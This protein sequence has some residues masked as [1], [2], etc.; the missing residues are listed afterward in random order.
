MPRD[1]VNV[2]L[3]ALPQPCAGR[4][5]FLCG[6]GGAGMNPLAHVLAARGALVSGSDACAQKSTEMLRAAGIACAIGHAAGQVRGADVFVYSS[7]IA[8]DNPEF[9]YARAHGIACLHRAHVLAQLVNQA[10][11]ITVAGTHGK[12]TTTALLALMLTTAG[13]DP[14]AVVGGVVPAFNAYHRLGQADWF[15]VETDE[16]DGSFQLFDSSLAVLL[17]IDA[18]H[19]DYYPDLAAIEAACARYVARIKP[20][21]TLV[22]NA[23][24]AHA[25][26]VAA[27]APAHVA[28]LACSCTGPASFRAQHVVLQPWS[29][30]FRV[31]E[32]GA[33]Y[34]VTVGVPGQH[35]VSNA[36]QALA[37]ARS[38]GVPVDAVQRACAAFHGVQR[39]FQVLGTCQGAT[40]MDDYAHHPREIEATLRAARALGQP[41]L[42]VFQPHRFTR[43]AKL[44]DDF[45]R[46]LGGL[47]RLILTEI[48]SASETP[49]AVTGRTLFDRV[50]A[51]APQTQYVA[52]IAAVPDAV[53]RACRAG[54]LV[55]FLGA[56]TI[57]AAAQQLIASPA[58]AH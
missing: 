36:L 32:A 5:Y 35:N 12:T 46:V 45:V 51:G 33:T 24:D 37:A 6:I 57:S 19:L 27:T 58:A 42:V 41:L 26:A 39:R 4:R 15:V 31:S 50:R 14:T 48:F 56:G 23:D 8:D 11:G 30:T 43:T 47:D 13:F 55:L 28:H 22:Y 53:R 40:I 29:S 2:D 20:G 44:L 16:S 18:D 54:D 10:R 3:H 52:D 1:L 9:H 17:N 25:T 38:I 49:G 7:A 34:P 21:G